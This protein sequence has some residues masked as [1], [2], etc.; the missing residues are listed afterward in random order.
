MFQFVCFATQNNHMVNMVGTEV[1]VFPNPTTLLIGFY[2][3]ALN[4]KSFVCVSNPLGLQSCYIL[5]QQLPNCN[6]I[7][8]YKRNPG[9]E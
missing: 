9:T 1:L 6:G 2:R 5:K 4:P 3:Q 7:Q 8:I